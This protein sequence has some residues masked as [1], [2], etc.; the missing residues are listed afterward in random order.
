[1][2]GKG[3]R[4]RTE[5]LN[6]LFLLSFY[7]LEFLLKVILT[8]PYGLSLGELTIPYPVIA[9]TFKFSLSLSLH[10]TTTVTSLAWSV[11]H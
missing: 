6:C 2:E 4:E 9:Q 10:N 8:T 11:T 3:I 5:K 1:M 7:S